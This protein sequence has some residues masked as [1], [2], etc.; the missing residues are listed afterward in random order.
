MK[1]RGGES[2]P[3]LDAGELEARLRRLLPELDLDSSVLAAL[4]QHY[5]ELRRWNRSVSL[6]GPGTGVAVVERHYG[7]SLAALPFLSAGRGRLVDVGSGA[8]FP[9]LV[10]AIARPGLEV[11]LLEARQRKAA[12]LEWV[13]HRTGT[14]CRIL[15]A[16][17]ALPLPVE[18]AEEIEFVTLR[19]VALDRGVLGALVARLGGEG[20][21]L[22][23]VG[24]QQ[25]SGER[26]PAPGLE[27]ESE[28]RLPGRPDERRLLR[29]WRR[30]G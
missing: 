12:F 30:R 25:G 10:L 1:H 7:E 3:V 23:W 9:G 28:V 21:V 18:L 19:A 24:P 4:H 5:E 17:L 27:L 20:R 13:A 11:T 26:S 6:V 22:H 16:H 2:V 14:R 8:G 15:C 29:V